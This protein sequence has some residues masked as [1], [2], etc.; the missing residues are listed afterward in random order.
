MSDPSPENDGQRRKWTRQ[1][2]PRRRMT[3]RLSQHHADLAF[4]L[5]ERH[6]PDFTQAQLFERIIEIAE[7]H[8]SSSDPTSRQ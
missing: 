2:T 1:T 3:I 5:A 7:A 4:D 6:F 8:L